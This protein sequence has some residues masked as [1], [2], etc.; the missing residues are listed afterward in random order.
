MPTKDSAA[1]YVVYQLAVDDVSTASLFILRA[2]AFLIW[3]F[4]LMLTPDL[5]CFLIIE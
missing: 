1:T 3:V 4:A 2:V 5:R